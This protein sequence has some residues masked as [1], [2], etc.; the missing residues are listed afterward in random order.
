MRLRLT[1]ALTVFAWGFACPAQTAWG[2]ISYSQ[3]SA[4]V[5]RN[6]DGTRLNIKVDP[7][8][9]QVEEVLED[10]NKNVV[11]RIVKDLDDAFQPKQATKYDAQS[12]VVSRHRYL[13]LR[14]RIEEEEIRDG[15][16]RFLS[17]L[18]FY[19]DTKGRMT[20]VEQLSAQGAVVSVSKAGGPGSNSSTPANSSPSAPTSR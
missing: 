11:W 20:R 8:N 1:Y 4:R 13:Y 5:V 12:R 17:K 2:Q 3:P 10:A 19:Y 16:N 7:H 6:A 9:Q 14:G 18:V 15:N